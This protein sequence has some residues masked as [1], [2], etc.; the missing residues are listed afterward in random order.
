MLGTLSK[1]KCVEGQGYA[2]GNLNLGESTVATKTINAVS[3][4]DAE[5]AE[6]GYKQILS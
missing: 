6:E 3:R 2:N 5:L 1:L 4:R